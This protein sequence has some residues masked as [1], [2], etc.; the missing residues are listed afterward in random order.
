L[1]G[2]IVAGVVSE[3][4]LPILFPVIVL[5]TGFSLNYILKFRK[6]KIIGIFLILAIGALNVFPFLQNSNFYTYSP[7]LKQRIQVSK[8]IISESEG[9]NY[10]LIGR[11][12]GSE[13]RSFTMNTEYLTWWLGKAPSKNNE[14]IKFFISEESGN[15]K[16]IKKE[17]KTTNSFN[18]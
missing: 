6:T 15:I 7:T 17:D 4:Y 8:K 1:L 18:F 14:E 9:H 3:A 10:N 2:I 13:F 5:L 11:G 16:L 12:I